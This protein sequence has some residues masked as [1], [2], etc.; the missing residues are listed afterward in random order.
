MENNTDGKSFQK[1]YLEGDYQD[2]KRKTALI[3]DLAFIWLLFEVSFVW[4]LLNFMC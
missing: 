3:L 1:A 4:R 2:S